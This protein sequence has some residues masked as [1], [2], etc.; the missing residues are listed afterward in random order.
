MGVSCVNALSSHLHVRVFREGKIFEQEYSCGKPLYD[1]R[2]IGDSDKTG[3]ETTFLPDNTIFQVSEYNYETL[4]NRVRE[5]SYLNK[6]ISIT[7]TDERTPD[8]DGK[9]RSQTFFSEGG[10]KEFVRFIDGP[11]TL[12]KTRS[13]FGSPA[14]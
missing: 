10:L 11:P 2:V 4:E 13:G 14:R 9:F 8:E 3:T 1:V 7:L 12:A 6:G 5:L